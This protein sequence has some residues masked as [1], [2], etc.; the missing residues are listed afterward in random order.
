MKF[1]R[2]AVSAAG[3]TAMIALAACSD[4]PTAPMSGGS[5]QAAFGNPNRVT[6]TD[7]VLRSG[8]AIVSCARQPASVGAKLI[9]PAGG[10]MNIGRHKFTVP[11]GALTAPTMI[12][13][14]AISDGNVRKVHF[15]PEGLQF[16]K[17]A[18]L[19]MRTDGCHSGGPM[20]IAYVDDSNV[21]L[22]LIDSQEIPH[23]VVGSISH[24]SD[25]AIAW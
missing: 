18:T 13:A 24:F 4:S 10:T 8:H 23:K 17:P 3:L 20:Q 2:F 9:G 7:E 16:A 1:T 25:Y 22:Y 5:I 6:S 19:E 15:E 21:I 12:T 11:A 14:T